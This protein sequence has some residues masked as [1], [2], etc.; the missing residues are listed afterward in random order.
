MQGLVSN[1][2][3]AGNNSIE[4]SNP[5]F[6]TVG[7]GINSMEKEKVNHWN[8][9]F[10]TV[11]LRKIMKMKLKLVQMEQVLIHQSQY[12]KNLQKK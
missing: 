11:K 3:L 1:E 12:L 6:A 9:I 2:H 5:T 10:K 7:L 4:I 8:Q